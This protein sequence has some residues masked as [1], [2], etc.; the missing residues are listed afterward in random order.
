MV[1]YIIADLEGV[2]VFSYFI[3]YNCG[4]REGSILLFYLIADIRVGLIY[5]LFNCGFRGG[6]ILLFYLIADSRVGFNFILF[7]CGFREGS[8]LLYLIA[9][10]RVIVLTF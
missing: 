1:F 5:I 4:F 2:V 7:N 6:S 8:M 3:L 10:I 9:D